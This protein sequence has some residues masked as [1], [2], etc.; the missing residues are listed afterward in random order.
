MNIVAAWSQAFL[1]TLL[2]EVAVAV[3]LLSGTGGVLRRALAVSF[4]QLLTHPAVW[5]ILPTLGWSRTP[6]LLVA[7]GW[8]I[9]GE[10]LFYR[11]VFP[12]LRWSRALAASALANAASYA[13]G[14][15]L[16]V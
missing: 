5:F 7:E 3:P 12:E 6:Y 16:G 2:I 4:G 14:T 9:T 15:W 1:A 11:F 13:I 8:A 10:L